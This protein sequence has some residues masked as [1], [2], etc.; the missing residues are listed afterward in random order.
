MKYKIKSGD[1]LTKISKRLGVSI[2]SLAKDNNIKDINKIIAGHT[3]DVPNSDKYIVEKNDNLTKIARQTNTTVDELV[4][5]NKI[6]NPN[7][8]YPGDVIKLPG[9]TTKSTSAPAATNNSSAKQPTPVKSTTVIPTNATKTAPAVTTVPVKKPITVTNPVKSPTKPTPA[10]NVVKTTT[11]APATPK[12]TAPKTTVKTATNSPIKTTQSSTKPSWNPP[13]A[14]NKVQPTAKP[15]VVK[16]EY[17]SPLNTTP[18]QNKSSW[19][20]PV[21][22]NATQAISRPNPVKK[23]NTSPFNTTPKPE[24]KYDSSIYPKIKEEPRAKSSNKNKEEI[25]INSIGDLFEMGTNYINRLVRKNIDIK[26]DKASMKIPTVAKDDSVPSYTGDTINVSNRRYIIPESI[27]LTKQKFG[28]RNRGEYN[29]IKSEAGSITAFHPFVDFEQ[30]NPTSKNT[31]IGIDK[32]GNFKAGLISDFQPGDKVTQTYSN[33]VIDFSKDPSGN[34]LFKPGS[35]QGSN[36]HNVP[37]VDVLDGNTKRRGSLNILIP[38]SNDMNSYGNITGG[39]L[40]AK[41]GN[42]TRLLSG[43]L[44]NIKDELA[45][46][47]ARNNAE[48]ATIYTLDNGSYNRGLRT[49]DRTFTPEDLRSYDMENSGGGNFLYLI[50]QQKKLNNSKTPNVENLKISPTY[51]SKNPNPNPKLDKQYWDVNRQQLEDINNKFEQLRLNTEAAI[52]AKYPGKKVTVRMEGATRSMDD[53]ARNYKSGASQTPISLHNFGAARDYD[54]IVGGKVHRDN[55]ENLYSDY[56]W[57]EAEKLGLGNLGGT[58]FGTDYRH[59]GLVPEGSPSTWYDLFEKY[60]S[61]SILPE[62]LKA[63]RILNSMEV[64]ENPIPLKSNPVIKVRNIL[65]SMDAAHE[66]RKNNLQFR[67]NPFNL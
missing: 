20:P 46:M 41:V 60:P 63:K 49:Y 6:K 32:E 34:M 28:I 8:I 65:N 38:K 45:A 64:E 4:S 33:Q 10:G 1:T 59:I 66:T 15:D 22:N 30:V 54:I 19:N 67:T 23:E 58:T 21:A 61:L 16:K 17:S 27:D 48:S 55:K 2:E 29:P 47:K 31:Y 5:L 53:A 26:E 18:S 24:K 50:D 39:R 42:E 62:T 13:V 36:R 3:L 7:L 9:S 25:G 11:P 51:W 56:L 44:Q 40:V 35:Q 37:M 43:S 52:Q 57:K 14:P 12:S